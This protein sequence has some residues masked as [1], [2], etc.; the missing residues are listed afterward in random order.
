MK[1]MKTKEW[2]TA[3]ACVKF[4]RI[5]SFALRTT[6]FGVKFHSSGVDFQELTEM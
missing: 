2:L 1:K 5:G 3:F 4:Y 6:I